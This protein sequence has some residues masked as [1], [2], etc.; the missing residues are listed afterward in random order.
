MIPESENCV[1]SKDKKITPPS[2]MNIMSVV[3]V[4]KSGQDTS[5]LNFDFDWML[6]W[7]H[8]PCG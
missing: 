2:I 3:Q 7:R 1:L 5:A 6:D 8:E 4:Q